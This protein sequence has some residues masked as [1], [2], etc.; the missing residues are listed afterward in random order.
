MIIDNDSHDNSYHNYDIDPLAQLIPY[1]VFGKHL[2]Q[3]LSIIALCNHMKN[4]DKLKY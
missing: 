2:N 4:N 1:K 3:T